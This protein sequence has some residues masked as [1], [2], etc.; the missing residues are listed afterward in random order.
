MLTAKDKSRVRRDF[1]AWTGGYGASE[2]EPQRIDLY[3]ELAMPSDLDPAE[4]EEYLAKWADL[5]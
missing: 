4:V 2:V 3:V 1:I 5:A